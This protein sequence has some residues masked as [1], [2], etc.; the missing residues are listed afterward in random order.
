MLVIVRSFTFLAFASHCGP[1]P[2]YGLF[3]FK[4]NVDTLLFN[5]F[6]WCKMLCCFWC[7]K[8]CCFG[9]GVLL[10]EYDS[11]FGMLLLDYDSMVAKLNFGKPMLCGTIM[12][13]ACWYE[14]CLLIVV[15][16]L[17]PRF[18]VCGVAEVDEVYGI[19]CGLCCRCSYPVGVWCGGTSDLFVCVLRSW[20][21]FVYKWC[22]GFRV[23]CVV[24]RF[25]ICV[26]C[27][28][29]WSYYVEDADV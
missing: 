17:D 20:V 22:D 15:L 4:G 3:P 13:P 8:L 11:I 21:R 24:S 9:F 2:I 26:R 28:L 6:D 7:S 5:P 1:R 19:S 29:Q 25:I 23:V 16:I 14:A 10:L 27:T 18:S 12:L